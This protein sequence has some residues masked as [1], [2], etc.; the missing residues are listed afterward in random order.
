MSPACLRWLP[1]AHWS[2]T[3]AVRCGR[4]CE[5]AGGGAV[6]RK[7][8]NGNAGV[9]PS[10]VAVGGPSAQAQTRRNEHRSRSERGPPSAAALVSGSPCC[11]GC[12]GRIR[13]VASVLAERV[14]R[15]AVLAER[16]SAGLRSG[17]CGNGMKRSRRRGAVAGA[18]WSGGMDRAGVRRTGPGQVPRWCAVP[19][20]RLAV[21]PCERTLAGPARP[22]VSPSAV[23]GGGPVGTLC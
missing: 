14:R 3:K 8:A 21:A 6:E 4:A 16:S 2:G 10:A 1:V 15:R 23:C 22:C 13:R 18:Q 19:V 5:V 20:A 12:V 9:R 11:G 17:T 7:E